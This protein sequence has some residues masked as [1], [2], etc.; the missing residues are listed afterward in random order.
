[1]GLEVPVFC[2]P[3]Y[4]GDRFRISISYLM[5]LAPLIN[6]VYDGLEV[7]FE[8][9]YVPNRIIDRRWKEFW[10]GYNEFD[11]MTPTNLMPLT[12]TDVGFEMIGG[13]DGLDFD[14][15]F[16]PAFGIGSLMDFLGYQFSDYHENGL[17]TAVTLTS[18]G[19]TSY[20]FDINALP[21]L[22]Y[23]RIY[24]DWYR[25][26]R[27]QPARLYEYYNNTPNTARAFA[28]QV[29]YDFAT[30]V[31]VDEGIIPVTLFTRNYKKDRFTTALP[32]PIIGGQVHIPVNSELDSRQ[33]IDTQN[34]TT[35]VINGDTTGFNLNA[36]ALG[37]IEQLKFAFKE[38][39]YRM[40]DTYNGNRYVESVES[41]Y[42]VR[43]PDSTLQRSLYL[44]SARDY[45]NFGEVYQT[46]SGDGTAN[47]GALGDYAG[48]G[49]ASGE[50]YLFDEEFYEHGFIFVLMCVNP[51]NHYYQG[52]KRMFTRFDRNEYFEP[53][54]QN[55]GD[56]FIKTIELF[57]DGSYH[58]ASSPIFGYNSRWIEMKT[59]YNELHGEFANPNSL[60]SSWNFARS[61]DSHPTISSEFS[62][63]LPVNKPFVSTDLKYD[64]FMVNML[65]HVDALRPVLAVE[66]F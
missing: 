9:F 36:L 57:N 44:G 53:E 60:Y 8:A 21:F 1:M 13:D 56:D 22:A 61:F 27:T 17:P 63:I 47:S 45:V 5:Q 6:P 12:L 52:I 64:N 33:A 42:G 26:E 66:S 54:F 51:V 3:V 2:E 55:I 31:S 35:G 65:L 37:T 59:R 43:V 19:T 18:Q 30:G 49:G 32:E 38:Y 58:D 50:H 16:N 28:A 24:D 23:S 39:S 46:S 48:R 34:G 10:T 14:T 11:Q 20:Q 25:N 15:L 29:S 62:R 4:P 7:N 41:H 40:K